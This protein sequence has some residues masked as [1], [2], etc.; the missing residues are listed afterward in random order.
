MKKYIPNFIT[1]LNLASGF[2]AVIFAADNNILMAAGFIAVAMVFDFCDGFAARVLNARSA[3]GKELDSLAD[4]VSFGVAPAVIM[5]QLMMAASP[6]VG[7]SVQLIMIF[8]MA[9][10]PVCAALRLAVFNLDTTQATSFRGLPTPANAIAVI[11]LA[12]TSGISDSSIIAFLTGNPVT[13]V[14]TTIVLSLLMVSR[15]E[16]FSLKV[17]NLKLKGNESRY[18]MLLMLVIAI[19]VTDIAGLTLIVPVYIVASLAS[20]WF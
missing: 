18:L 19:A 11:S 15:I 16:L 20:R 13:I 3:I 5:Y 12:V 14:I 4:V 1:S 17:S 7:H 9:V 8:A 6:S 2:A 10:M